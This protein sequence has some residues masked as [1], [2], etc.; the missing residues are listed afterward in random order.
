MC[1]CV[2]AAVLA[3][4][5]ER[6]QQQEQQLLAAAAAKGRKRR[7]G[8]NGKEG[9]PFLKKPASAAGLVSGSP[10]PLVFSSSRPGSVLSVA[11]SAAVEPAPVVSE[12]PAAG[13]TDGSDMSRG[14]GG[15]PVR[16]KR[17]AGTSA[18]LGGRGKI[19]KKKV[20]GSGSAAASAGA[21]AGAIA[22]S[23]AA[24]VYGYGYSP[25]TISPSPSNSPGLTGS[26]QSSPRVSPVPFQT[27][28][29]RNK[30]SS[31][32]SLAFSKNNNA[33]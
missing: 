14:N 2:S 28:P 1:V 6:R 25:H 16:P 29:T 10:S 7:G 15:T 26:S 17:R 4:Q 32:S 19:R 5:A 8:P 24:Q 3:R 21:I 11:S 9:E 33:N 30:C 12:P 13:E 18:P 31:S 20:G 23:N 27:T 22:A